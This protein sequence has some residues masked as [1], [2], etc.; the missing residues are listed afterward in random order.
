MNV[1]SFRRVSRVLCAVAFATSSVALAAE[2]A[3]KP[4][5]AAKGDDKA[6]SAPKAGAKAAANSFTDQRDKETYK[7]GVFD[8]KTW[9]LEPLR[10]KPEDAKDLI[11]WGDSASEK[12]K[13]LFYGRDLVDSVIPSGWH[14]PTET[15]VKALLAKIGTAPDALAKAGFAVE[16]LQFNLD[17][18]KN[19]MQYKN[20][21]FMQDTLQLKAFRTPK[22]AKFQW[23]DFLAV[24][25][26]E[27]KDAAGKVTVTKFDAALRITAKETLAAG[28]VGGYPR[29]LL[30]KD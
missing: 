18:Y 15:E 14:V 28:G 22:D 1:V 12:A 3:A 9:F 8:G 4:D 20:D 27:S 11:Y 16:A 13:G 21:Q 23:S 6:K 17:D 24:R 29:L 5:K 26:I 2:P 10:H 30:V 19:A 25:E 7:T